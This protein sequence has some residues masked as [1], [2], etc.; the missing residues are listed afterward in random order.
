MSLNNATMLFDFSHSLSYIYVVEF[1][2]GYGRRDDITALMG[3]GTG[4]CALL[5]FKNFSL[6]TCS[7]INRYDPQKHN[8]LRFSVIFKSVKE[9][10]DQKSFRS[11]VVVHSTQQL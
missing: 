3:D 11:T 10:R 6:L 8:S 9:H 5:C 1:S 7:V 2:R 4:A